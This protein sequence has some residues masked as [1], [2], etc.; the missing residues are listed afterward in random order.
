M[1]QIFFP[2]W[3]R[4][5]YRLGNFAIVNK[6]YT[7][8]L[9]AAFELSYDRRRP[10]LSS[11]RAPARRRAGAAAPADPVAPRLVRVEP[12]FSPPGGAPG[13]HPGPVHGDRKS[14]RL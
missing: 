11:A 10:N 6:S 5:F 13:H 8:N 7:Y 4:L 1:K 12:G 14:T 3:T 2:R 9:G